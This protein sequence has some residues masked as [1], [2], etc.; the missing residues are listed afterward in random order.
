[1]R[2]HNFVDNAPNTN[3]SMV[4]SHVGYDSWAI[5]TTL[6][7]GF[8]ES[9][10]SAKQ[11]QNWD[12][13]KEEKVVFLL[14]TSS[15]VKKNPTAMGMATCPIIKLHDLSVYILKNYKTTRSSSAVITMVIWG[16]TK[17]M[18][19][20]SLSLPVALCNSRVGRND[21]TDRCKYQLG[22]ELTQ[23]ESCGYC[24]HLVKTRLSWDWEPFKK[25]WYRR[26][27]KEELGFQW[28]WNHHNSPYQ[29]AFSILF[30]EEKIQQ[31]LIWLLLW[32]FLT[33]VRF[34][35]YHSSILPIVLERYDVNIPTNDSSG[36]GI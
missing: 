23:L 26:Q 8:A 6:S 1:M 5:F 11:K 18:E 31:S 9:K 13:S 7:I 4:V 22:R 33:G 15:F 29:S 27:T 3:W 21:Q 32:I 14:F 12:N 34:Q 16:E 35:P 20:S 2:P 24:S 17:Q 19:V 30:H 10:A 25:W 28:Q 36:V